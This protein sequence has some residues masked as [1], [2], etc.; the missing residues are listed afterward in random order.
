L[1]PFENASIDGA[2]IVI[3]AAAI[4]AMPE[5]VAS[6]RA[7]SIC[8]CTPVQ[9]GIQAHDLLAQICDLVQKQARQVPHRR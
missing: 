3:A 5:M 9:L 2:K 8:A 4:A 6:R 7:L 1:H